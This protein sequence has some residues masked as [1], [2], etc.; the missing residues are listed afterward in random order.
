MC[1]HLEKGRAQGGGSHKQ[2]NEAVKSWC[3]HWQYLVSLQ[4][5]AAVTHQGELIEQQ[6]KNSKGRA[7][8][9]SYKRCRDLGSWIPMSASST[10][11]FLR[12]CPLEIFLIAFPSTGPEEFWLILKVQ[13]KYPPLLYEV[14]CSH[15]LLCAPT[16][17]Y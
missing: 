12:L 10:L 17:F 15:S 6:R 8:H 5:E 11:K 1:C 2:G 14:L 3:S 16:V 13:L 4:T 9:F 7:W